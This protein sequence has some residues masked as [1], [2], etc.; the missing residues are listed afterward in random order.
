MLKNLTSLILILTFFKVNGQVI[1]ISEA[2]LR[3]T[4]TVVTVRGMATHGVEIGQRIRY[5]QS[6][7]IPP[8]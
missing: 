8:L 5:F 7:G 4:G 6:G 1:K 3:D 2:R